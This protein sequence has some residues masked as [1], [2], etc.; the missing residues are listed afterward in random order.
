MIF[1]NVSIPVKMNENQYDIWGPVIK[2]MNSLYLLHCTKLLRAYIFNDNSRAIV[3]DM[4]T[5][6]HEISH[7]C[8][9]NEPLTTSYNYYDV[10]N[11]NYRLMRKR[12]YF[13]SIHW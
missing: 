11:V 1:I 3:K 4:P 10:S 8:A 6:P 9:A 12:R 5:D 2:L 13:A 7:G